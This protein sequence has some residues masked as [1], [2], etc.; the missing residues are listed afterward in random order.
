M[1]QLNRIPYADPKKVEGLPSEAK[2]LLTFAKDKVPKSTYK[3][4]ENL[5]V[6][7]SS[8]DREKSPTQSEKMLY[9]GA[10]TMNTL[11]GNIINELGV[12]NPD[13]IPYEIYDRMAQDPTIALGLSVI[14]NTP[15]GLNW[16][17]ECS[18]EKQ[19][20]FITS[21]VKNIY[22]DTIISLS[23]AV[24]IGVAIG[25]KVWEYKPIKIYSKN[26]KGNKI[27]VFDDNYWVLDKI[28]FVHPRTLRIK[29]D[30]KGNFDGV[31]QRISG[32][33]VNVKSDKIVIYSHNIQFGNYYGT[34]RLKNV[35]PAWYW[36]SVL[37]QFL[38][39]Y[40]ERKGMPLTEI[41]APPGSRTDDRG[42]K[43]DNMTH[44][45]KVG[46]AA[47]SNSV[48]VLPSEF[49]K[50][51]NKELWSFRHI[52]DDQRG[53]MFI[54]ILNHMDTL[55]L[56]G[57]F[58]PDKMGLAS[59]GSPHSASGSSAGDSL[60]VFIMTEQS[61]IND[62]ENIFDT[63]IIPQIQAYNFP[64][65]QIEEATLKIE[66]LDYNK[67]LLLKDVFLRMIMLSSGSIR[68]GK[69]PKYLPSV[70]RMAEM[71]DL[72][73]DGF[74]DIFE[75]LPI[76]MNPIQNPENSNS[77]INV[78]KDISPTIEKKNM[79]DNN[80]ANRATQRKERSTRERSAREKR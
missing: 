39:K 59:D 23:D 67:K 12:Y 36:S 64:S 9:G 45:L 22:R 75:N 40:M 62:I 3:I 50:D 37:N 15:A 32:R 14:K 6:D 7:I 52:P 5:F 21:I 56:R 73:I 65:E 61:V 55:K 35:Y 24:R 44:A 53:D 10:L 42:N 30:K 74:E 71:L 29:L 48:V 38:L 68:D 31:I 13:V 26:A 60:D 46:Q 11:F 63:Q 41:K 47:M 18:D 27:K 4:M 58:I 49:S 19:R 33:T 54:Q 2:N 1:A 57:L 8:Y 43:V 79:I 51:G 69:A 80:N 28:K 34:S 25:E 20:T 70:K 16:R 76:S 78:Q 72:P 77:A 66:K 17:I